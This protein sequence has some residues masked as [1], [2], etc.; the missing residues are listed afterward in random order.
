RHQPSKTGPFGIGALIHVIHVSADIRELNAWYEDVFGGL[1]FL[2]LD[3]PTYLAEEKR[4]ASLLMI[5]DYCVETVAPEI[6]ADEQTG[7]GRFYARRGSRLHSIGYVSEDVS[8]LAEE[9]NASGVRC[10][11][12]RA[13]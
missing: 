10:G 12:Q 13:N 11:L 8:A 2:G 5:S 3:E 6:P 1:V 4:W 7:F 9:L